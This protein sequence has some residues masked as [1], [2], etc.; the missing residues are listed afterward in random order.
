MQ[1]NLHHAELS[2]MGV[3]LLWSL[4]V[5]TLSGQIKVKLVLTYLNRLDDTLGKVCKFNVTLQAG[6]H[7]KSVFRDLS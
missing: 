6:S 3:F 4:A 2:L 5:Y 7:Y 1:G